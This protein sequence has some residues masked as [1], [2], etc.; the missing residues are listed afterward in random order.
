MTCSWHGDDRAKRPRHD[1]AEFRFAAPRIDAG[2]CRPRCRARVCRRKRRVRG[3]A[4]WGRG[5]RSEPSRAASAVWRD[6]GRSAHRIGDERRRRH[7]ERTRTIRSGAVGE[8]PHRR[9]PSH[10]RGDGLVSRR[11]VGARVARPACDGQEVRES[12]CRPDIATIHT[13]FATSA[14]SAQMRGAL[15]PQLPR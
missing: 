4:Q 1:D 2:H 13:P 6:V 14:F 12:A 15:S 9:R 5:R 10:L 8:G 3:A 7:G 11:Y